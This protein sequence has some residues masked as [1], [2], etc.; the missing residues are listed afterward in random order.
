VHLQRFGR[1]P[2]ALLG[3][4]LLVVFMAVGAA[5]QERGAPHAPAGAQTVADI[6]GV[7]LFL[8][9]TALLERNIQ[10]APDQWDALF[11]TPGYAALTRSEFRKEFF[12]DRFNLAFMPSRKAELEAQ[13]KRDR[14][15]A[16]YVQAKERR[17]EIE[18]RA[19]Q[20]ALATADFDRAVERAKALLPTGATQG[21]TPRV[22]F[23]VFAADSRGYDPVVFDILY[24][25]RP[26]EFVDLAAHEFHHWYRRRVAPDFQRDM[27]T[28]WVIDQIH[29]EGVADQL[30]V[31]AWIGRPPE[32]LEAPEREY[33]EF[34]AKS[35][36][37]IREM[38]RLFA[39]MYAE[40]A[41]RRE[42]GAGL[43]KA[44]PRSGHP[45]GYFMAETIASVLGRR[46]LID[47]ASNPFA[48]F[49]AYD[50]AARKRGQNAPAFSKP[51]LQLLASL[52]RRYA[53]EL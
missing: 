15:L 35:A 47:V 13:V 50:K 27:D 32:T 21:A 40:P 41:K 5:A 8:E 16:H 20:L 2:A 34:L 33:V 37:V 9:L 48:F 39:Q 28:L 51:A 19:G 38:D 42:L 18:Q 46:A 25:T 53:G 14:Y 26:E 6:S 3:Q 29:L 11:A 44:V 49:R 30:N 43:K 23:V 10:P 12:V 52:E 22:A 24:K 45:T 1:A 4:V 36:N 7:R 17:K 31:P